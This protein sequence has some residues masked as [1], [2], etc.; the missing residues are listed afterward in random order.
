[1]ATNILGNEISKFLP[2]KISS[3]MQK[4]WVEDARVPVPLP[5]VNRVHR[6]LCKRTNSHVYRLAK[7]TRVSRS[8]MKSLL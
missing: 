3:W 5:G 8:A 6:L 1:M 2:F 4:R 7:Y